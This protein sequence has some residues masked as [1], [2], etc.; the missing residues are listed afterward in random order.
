MAP[1]AHGYKLSLW[2]LS[3]VQCICLEMS[4]RKCQ[5]EMYRAEQWMQHNPE[6]QNA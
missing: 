6:N 3:K 4:I 2:L 1:L 5:P